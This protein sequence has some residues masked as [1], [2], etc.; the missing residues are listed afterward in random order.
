MEDVMA[1]LTNEARL[2]F[3][4]PADLKAVI[5][6]AAAANGQ[7]VSDFAV[8]TLARAARE[9]V[10][11]QEVTVLTNR[12]RD[13]FLALLDDP[14]FKPNDALKKAAARYKKRHG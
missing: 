3:R 7:T 14:S 5:E 12:D 10:R 2:N 8:S 4:L 6:Q 13:R 9:V 11:Q 1:V